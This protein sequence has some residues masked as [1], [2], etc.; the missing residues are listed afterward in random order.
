MLKKIFIVFCLVL[1]AASFASARRV[2]PG[3]KQ[4]LPDV[5]STYGTIAF[6]GQN[7]FMKVLNASGT[8]E[9]ASHP[10]FIVW[11]A[12]DGY[13]VATYEANSNASAEAFLGPWY[14]DLDGD[15]TIEAAAYGWVQIGGSGEVYV[16]NY[17]VAA[18]GSYGAYGGDISIGDVLVG[19][20]TNE[21][22]TDNQRSRYFMIK[23]R[24][25]QTNSGTPETWPQLNR[26]RAMGTCTT[27]TVHTIPVWLGS[28]IY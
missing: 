20:T 18:S 16:S 9:Y 28:G 19:V 25:P 7:V 6:D 13:S 23:A 15:L 21:S 10:A 5:Q 12:A 11:E 14:C 24:S 8:S 1:M 4:T 27:T 3:F 2:V 17:A 22:T 26:P